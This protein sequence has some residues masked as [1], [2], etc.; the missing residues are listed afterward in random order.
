MTL[1]LKHMDYYYFFLL[2][3]FINAAKQSTNRDKQLY[4]QLTQ[5]KLASIIIY[6]GS[7][8]TIIYLCSLHTI[9]YLCSMINLIKTLYSF[10]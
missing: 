3:I 6:L 9:I 8:H 7:L 1:K 10:R 2:K 5:Y 4:N